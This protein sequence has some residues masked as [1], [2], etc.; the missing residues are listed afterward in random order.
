VRKNSHGR[1]IAYDLIAHRYGA[2]RQLQP[3]GG[4]YAANMDFINHD[5]WVT[6]T[7]P[8]F[9]SYVDLPRYASQRRPLT[10]HPTTV[11]HCTPALHLARTE[12]FGSENG[13]NNGTGVALTFWTGFY[14]KP[15]DLFDGSPLYRPP[16][17]VTRE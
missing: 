16:Q 6:R 7:E 13:K 8:G 15:R 4:T 14:L 12:D 2:P 17:P 5:F 3:E 10:G 1:P 9:T 11:W